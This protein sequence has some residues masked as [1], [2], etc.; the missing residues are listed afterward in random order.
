MAEEGILSGDRAWFFDSRSPRR[1]MGVASH[2]EQ[3]VVVLSLWTDDTCTATFRLPLADAAGLISA[4]ADGLV[5]GIPAARTVVAAPAQRGWRAWLA[6]VRRR[7][8]VAEGAEVVPL[9]LVK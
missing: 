5:S 6:R 9:T 2:P 1:R 3:G 8:K 4:L 7:T